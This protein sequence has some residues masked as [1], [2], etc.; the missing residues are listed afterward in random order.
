MVQ[1]AAVALF[2]IGY[3]LITLEGTLKVGKSA[4]ALAMGAVLWII[5]AVHDPALVGHEIGLASADIFNLIVFLI[6]AMSL[7]E[8]A[9]HYRA[10]DLIKSKICKFQLTE[11]SQ[12]VAIAFTTFFLSSVLDDLT[13]TIVMIQIARKFFTGRNFAVSA[14]AIVIAANSGGAWSPIG[15]VTSIML[16]LANKFTAWELISFGFVPAFALICTAVALMKG[17]I[18]NGPRVIAE[19]PEQV[20]LKRSE[21]FVLCLVV[22]SFFLPIAVKPLGLPPVIGTLLGL[23]LTW[24]TVDVFRRWKPTD[25]HLSATIEHLLQKADLSSIKFFVGIL[26][27]VAVLSSLGILDHVSQF[28]YGA[29]DSITRFI[30]GHAAL[31]FASAILDNIALT[32][33]A[34]K[35]VPSVDPYLWVLLALAVGTGGSMLAVGS[36]SGVVASGLAKVSFGEYFKIGFVPACVGLVVCIAVWFAQYSLFVA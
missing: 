22:V 32:A 4:V 12:F 30:A 9:G 10:F 14:V 1:V 25:T 13:T 19:Q 35:M 11:R 28:I 16:W 5:L 18:E 21:V 15:D 34:I 8:I 31:G 33:I 6:A 20:V 27:S 23:G 17:K 26:L 24:L 3:L 36:A 7:V 2:I 29:G